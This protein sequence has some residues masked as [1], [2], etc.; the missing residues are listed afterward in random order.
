METKAR[1][2][3]LQEALNLAKDA[4]YALRHY[5]ENDPLTIIGILR[6]AID[7][8]DKIIAIDERR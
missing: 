3:H 8:I 7:E 2:K 4:E 6:D 5:N 1:D